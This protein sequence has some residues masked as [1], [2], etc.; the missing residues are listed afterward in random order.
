MTDFCHL[1]KDYDKEKIDIVINIKGNI[2][3]SQVMGKTFKLLSERFGKQNQDSQ[4]I[5]I[6]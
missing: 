6:N 2:I 5:P 1:K 4:S 3:R